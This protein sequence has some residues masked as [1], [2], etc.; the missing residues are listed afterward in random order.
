M[1]TRIAFV[2]LSLVLSLA[3]CGGEA[4]AEGTA[5][6]STR[7]PD[8]APREPIVRRLTQ[9]GAE[10]LD[11]LRTGGIDMP[12]EASDLLSSLDVV[13]DLSRGR[14]TGDV[15]VPAAETVIDPATETCVAG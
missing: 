5:S 10:V 8:A 4:D 11:V 6:S 15:E 12:R 7:T 1:R 13:V 14:G 2:A 9:R 3:A